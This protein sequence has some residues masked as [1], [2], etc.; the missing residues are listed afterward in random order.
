ML[1]RCLT[2]RQPWLVI[3]RIVIAASFM[4]SAVSAVPPPAPPMGTNVPLTATSPN[5]YRMGD[6]ELSA[7]HHSLSFPATVNVTDVVIE[8]ALVTRDGK[9]HESLLSTAV[10]ARDL[11]LASLLLGV[12]A[13]A[14]LGSTN[15]VIAPASSGQVRVWVEWG[16]PGASTYHLRR[17]ED[18]IGLGSRDSRTITGKLSAA[19]WNYSGS[20][21]HEGRFVAQEEG[22]IISL[23]R[24]PVA[25]INNP[26]VDRDDDDIH[27]PNPMSLPPRGTLVRVIW[28]FNAP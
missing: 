24:D 7:Q 19:S 18:L 8:Y 12:K 1:F 6:I 5:A 2:P 16:T 17:L 23:I 15:Q 10:S 21:V 9:T 25:L 20:F 14:D 26:G 3:F 4:K 11:H 22:S 28:E 27:Y 13:S